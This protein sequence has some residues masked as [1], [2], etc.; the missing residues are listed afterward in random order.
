MSVEN[1]VHLEKRVTCLEEVEETF[2]RMFAEHKAFMEGINC[3]LQKTQVKLDQIQKYLI[4]CDKI[5]DGNLRALEELVGGI[6]SDL[7]K[8][9]DKLELHTEILKTHDHLDTGKVSVP[10]GMVV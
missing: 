7:H 2:K 3:S 9:E 6:N 4:D 5:T 1:W 10:I 8:A